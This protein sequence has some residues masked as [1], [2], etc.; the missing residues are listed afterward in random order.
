MSAKSIYRLI[1]TVLL[2]L[3]LHAPTVGAASPS[4]RW[5]GSW[6]SSETGHQG[7][8]RAKIRQV[9]SNTYRALFAG[10]F[11][12][13]VPF[14]YPAKLE[15]VPGSPSSYQSTTRLPL[16][17]QYQMTAIVTQSSFNASFRGKKDLGG[18]QMRR[19]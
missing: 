19:Q 5:I 14:V 2:V 10:R 8:L 3:F 13:V 15:R 1:P 6:S 16:L 9:D 7:P 4:G 18:F 12:K 17:G 11:A